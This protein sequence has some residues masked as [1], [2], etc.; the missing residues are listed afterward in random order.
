MSKRN[1]NS[2]SFLFILLGVAFFLLIYLLSFLIVLLPFV[3]VAGYALK[4][5]KVD[6]TKK[7]IGGS[8]SDFW[9]NETE[10]KHFKQL[11]TSLEQTVHTINSFKNKGYSAGISINKDGSFSQRSNLGKEI[12]RVLKENQPKELYLRSQLSELEIQPYLQWESFNKAIV[13]AQAYLLAF[14]AWL[15][16]LG[17]CQIGNTQIKSK[18]NFFDSY[19]FLIKE[20]I[21]GEIHKLSFS[22]VEIQTVS[23]A[24][25]CAIVVFFLTKYIWALRKPAVKYSPEPDIVSLSNV[26][27]Y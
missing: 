10:K 19:F 7:A 3:L 15:I 1:N 6:S 21:A 9:L 22:D 23:I 8:M 24:S 26:D 16:G 18:L 11:N 13:N 27:A 17:V 14:I 2:G 5:I 4:S 20:L 12:N 25:L